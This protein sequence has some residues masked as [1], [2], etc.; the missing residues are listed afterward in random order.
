MHPKKRAVRNRV[1]KFYMYIG[2]DLYT[3]SS[4]C[5]IWLILGGGRV[6]SGKIVLFDFFRVAIITHAA[7]NYK[8]GF[9]TIKIL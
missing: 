7:A 5:P 9:R 8:W 2:F 3:G 4:R 1:W 6:L